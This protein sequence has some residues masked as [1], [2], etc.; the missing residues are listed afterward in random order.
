MSAPG[1][2]PSGCTPFEQELVNAMNDYVN[3]AETPHFATDA[4]VR[5]ARRKKATAIAGIATALVLASAGTALAAG[6][7]GGG[8]HTARPA[9]AASATDGTTVLYGSSDGTNVTVPLAGLDSLGVRA[10]IVPLRLTPDFTRTPVANCRQ[11]T[12][13][14]VSP[15]APTV[16]HAG[17][18]VHVTVCAG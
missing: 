8:E 10:A 18:T 3:S 2:R 12:V 17:D 15:H 9:A 7:V 1:S 16:V 4:I 6:V 5:R 13:V 14:A 11:G